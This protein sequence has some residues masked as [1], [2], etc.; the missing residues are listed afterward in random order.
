MRRSRSN[1]PLKP[2][3][4]PR[5]PASP[6]VSAGELSTT[7]PGHDNHILAVLTRI[8]DTLDRLV[9][10]IEQQNKRLGV[11][12]GTRYT[13]PPEPSGLEDEKTMAGLLHISDRTL[14]RHRRNGRLPGCSIR[15]GGR[16]LWKVAETREAWERGIA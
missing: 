6:Q 2:S 8:A 11:S 16:I 9:E 4:P 7:S 14:G 10:G 15:N 5:M 13:R 3:P 1:T 12:E